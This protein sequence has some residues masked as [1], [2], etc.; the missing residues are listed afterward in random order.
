MPRN[1][2][3]TFIVRLPVEEGVVDPY[4]R[5]ISEHKDRT[6]APGD[7]YPT[8]FDYALG[9]PKLDDNTPFAASYTSVPNGYTPTGNIFTPTAPVHELPRDP[10]DLSQGYRDV[11][12]DE[13][14]DGVLDAVAP[15]LT[16]AE[17]AN[18]R[19]IVITGTITAVQPDA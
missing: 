13:N 11:A 5:V 18:L 9:I 16:G 12:P 10:S 8:E 17:A 14:L 7:E 15:N 2:S 4:L 1:I 3:D 6:I 19:E